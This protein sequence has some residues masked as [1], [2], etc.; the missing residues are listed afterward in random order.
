MTAGSDRL[1]SGNLD[2]DQVVWMNEISRDDWVVGGLALLLV[3]ALLLLPWFSFGPYT[4]SATDG[5]DGW[6]AILAVLVGI[7]VI[8]DLL[9]ERL[10]P[11]TTVPNLGASRTETRFRLALIAAGFIGLKFLLH[12]HFSLFG[13]GFWASILLAAAL[14]WATHRLSHDKQILGAG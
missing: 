12:I 13:F 6:A 2:R 14:V 10:S 8:A 11:Q 7:A 1:G 5:P 3:I 9:I 4:L